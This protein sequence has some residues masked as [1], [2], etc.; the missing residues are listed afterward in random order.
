MI[1]ICGC[2]GSQFHEK[3][4]VFLGNGIFN[5]DGENWRKE[6]KTASLQFSSNVLRDFSIVVFRDYSVA[7]ADILHG[8][9]MRQQSV[10]M[11]VEF[12]VTAT[13]FLK[14]LANFVTENS[15]IYK[16]LSLFDLETP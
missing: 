5:A 8:A 3:F 4:D 7:L 13:L 11:Q 9:A 12:Q 15:P 10:D 14:I 1:F 16:L 6:R 2:Q